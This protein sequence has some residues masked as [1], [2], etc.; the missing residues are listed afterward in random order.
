M[1]P[2]A[3]RRPTGCILIALL[4]VVSGVGQGLHLIPHCGHAVPVADAFLLLGADV[5]ERPMEGSTEVECP[6]GE[7]IPVYDEDQ[8]AICSVVGQSCTGTDS[9]QLV[10]VL[11]LAEELPPVVLSEAPGAIAHAFG[12][13][14]PPLV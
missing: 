10:L 6:R 1:V 5:S 4:T 14:A 13:R 2:L 7:D 3:V 11:P 9:F 8:C 12:A